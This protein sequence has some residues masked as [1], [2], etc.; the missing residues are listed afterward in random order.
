MPLGILSLT[1]RLKSRP[2]R[3]CS[4]DGS[5]DPSELG[6]LAM[7]SQGLRRGLYPFAA[8]RLGYLLLPALNRWAIVGRPFRALGRM[9]ICARDGFRGGMAEAIA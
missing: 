8:S 9:R 2:S 7:V 4:D 5:C 6:R 3:T 1:A